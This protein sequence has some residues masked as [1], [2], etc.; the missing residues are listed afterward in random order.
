[1]GMESVHQPSLD[2]INK[3]I[4]V[5]RARQTIALFKESGIEV[6]LYLIMGLPGEPEDIVEKTWSFL[7]ETD[8][9]LVILSLFTVRPGTEVFNHPEKF[10]IKRIIGDPSKTMHMFGRYDSE[11]P[12]LT[13]EYEPAA[14]WGKSLSA[15]QIIDNYIELQNRLKQ[16]NI[17]NAYYAK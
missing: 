10:G 6:R 4:S 3:R 5:E 11:R 9:D 12:V 13:F 2:L 15:D 16:R 14:P 7:C 1:M 17:S 8:P